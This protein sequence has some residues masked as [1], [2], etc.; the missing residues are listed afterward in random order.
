MLDG[1]FSLTD[2]FTPT[3][4]ITPYEGI[5]RAI[6]L[7]TLVT[8]HWVAIAGQIAALLV[9]YFGFGLKLP[10]FACLVV[11]GVS[12]A[13]NLVI[14][15]RHD[16]LRRIR[17]QSAALYLAFDIIQLSALLYLT[18]GLEN[19]FSVLILAP[20][21]VSATI[22]STSS[23]V[24]LSLFAAI[25]ST[26]LALWHL[27]LPWNG[28]GYALEP[29]YKFGLWAAITIATVFITA[30]VWLV[31]QDARRL[32]QAFQESQLAL[33]REQ[34]MSALGALAA[35]AAHELS[36]PLGTIA[37][38]A[39]EIVRDLPSDSPLEEDAHLLS[40][41]IERCRHI[42]ARLS[43]RPAD[44][45]HDGPLPRVPLSALVEKAVATYRRLGIDIIIEPHGPEGPRLDLT[46]NHDSTNDLVVDVE[47][48]VRDTS[49]MQHGLATLI[50][51][52]VQ[53]AAQTVEIT[54]YWDTEGFAVIIE[55]DGPGFPT[56]VLDR[57]GEPFVSTRRGRAGHMGLGIFIA[58][59]LLAQTGASTDF[60]NRDEGG[61]RVAVKWM[62]EH[63]QA[64][65]S[66]LKPRGGSQDG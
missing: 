50:Q 47:P 17:E 7:R 55:D 30:Y 58:Q 66:D 37:V 51:N 2:E 18:G 56:T 41:E 44:K 13:I 40:S 5:W 34:R 59:N 8:I 12:A 53:F 60:G 49:E 1:N 20:I 65:N 21:M 45:E 26:L 61:A 42:L 28:D 54:V 11:I 14:H 31:A 19:P 25:C 52:A 36:S 62:T 10:L 43:E 33:A 57:I 23:T 15:A 6:R 39:K 27:P 32:S 16:R 48:A 46:L 64:L 9:I 63:N 38:I 24:I 29:V 4:V 3:R 22:L 35:S